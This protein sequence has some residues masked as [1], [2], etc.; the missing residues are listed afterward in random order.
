MTIIALIKSNEE[1]RTIASVEEC[2][3]VNSGAQ[4]VY[5]TFTFPELRKVEK[6]LQIEVETDPETMAHLE[7]PQ[8]KTY[9]NNTVGMTLTCDPTAGTTLCFD[10]T[11]IGW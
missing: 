1:Q 9:L 6:V 5:V 7:L 3:V 8:D 4:A 2:V 11:A 10:C